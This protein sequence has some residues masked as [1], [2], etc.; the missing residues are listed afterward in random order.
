MYV[1]PNCGTPFEGRVCPKCCALRPTAAV[2]GRAGQIVKNRAASRLDPNQQAAQL[3]EDLEYS[4][5]VYAWRKEQQRKEEARQR[6]AQLAAAAQRQNAICPTEEEAA[7]QER[8]L[9]EEKRRAQ[10]EEERARYAQQ[11]QKAVSWQRK[12]PISRASSE[13]VDE[14]SVPEAL[15]SLRITGNGKKPAPPPVPQPPRRSADSVR[16]TVG[17]ESIEDVRRLVYP[18]GGNVP[19]RSGKNIGRV[20]ARSERID[21]AWRAFASGEKAAGDSSLLP[22]T[23]PSQD[24]SEALPK[25]P[26]APRK[27][28]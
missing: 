13:E 25:P 12:A 9:Q 4:R 19:E 26:P 11:A 3:A 6:A 17:A 24:A 8:R 10:E 1:C 21:S 22:Q 18:S 27:K 7:A 16:N 23:T 2:L 20:S 14:I 5:K 28:Q 15:R